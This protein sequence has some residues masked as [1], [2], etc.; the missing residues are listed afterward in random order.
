VQAITLDDLKRYHAEALAPGQAAFHV[1]G[2]VTAREVVASLGGLATRWADRD[3]SFPAPP[4][5]SA[6]RAGLYFLDVPDAKQ[7]VLAIGY[8]AL[9]ETDQDFYPATVMNFRLGGGGFASDLT[10]V[11]REQR[12][13][14]YGIRSG[15]SGTTLPGPFSIT[16]SVRSNVTYESLA[17]I[18]DLVERHGPEFDAEDLEATKSFLIKNNARAFETLAAK[19]G[20]LGDMSAYGFPADYVRQREQIVQTMTVDRIKELADAYLDPQ[21]MVWLVVGDA[22]T[23]MGRLSALGLGQPIPIDREGRPLRVTAAR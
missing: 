1:A 20:M 7:S 9:A 16:S 8:L 22:R 4:A 17:L 13:Y 21:R 5:W 15:F 19:V 3:V 10:Q 12:G 18:K 14:T 6:D 11:L 23:Q 2:A